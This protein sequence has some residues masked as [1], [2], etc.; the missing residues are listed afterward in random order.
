MI[1]YTYENI[2]RS[3]NESIHYQFF[4]ENTPNK[5]NFNWHYHPEIELTYI[6]QGSGKRQ[7][8]TNLSTYTNGDLILIGSNLNHMGFTDS[9]RDGKIEIVIQFLPDFLGN[10]IELVPEFQPIARLFERAK[11]GLTFSDPIKTKVGEAL[12]GLVYEE[13][14]QGLLTLINILNQLA[15]ADA[16]ELNSSFAFPDSNQQNDR[17]KK[18]FNFIKYNFQMEIS[19]SMA[20]DK[21]N[22]TQHAFCR[23]FKKNT[24]KTFTQFVNEYRINHAAKLLI[25]TELDIKTIS[26]ESGYNNFSNF[27]RFFKKHHNITPKGF[28]HNFLS[29][30]TT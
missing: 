15:S 14:L 3:F 26:Y 4:D 12:E 13:K 2:V 18:L 1:K 11:H 25:E 24:G 30:I 17:L 7:V 19:L 22:M 28:R 23:Y 16:H 29:E 10:A 6:S 20:A 21:M 27:I 9:F 8:G 5:K